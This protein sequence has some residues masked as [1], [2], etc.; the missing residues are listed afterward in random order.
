MAIYENAS[1]ATLIEVKDV[2]H[3]TIAGTDGRQM[4]ALATWARSRYGLNFSH[5]KRS[6]ER[7]PTLGYAVG[8]LQDHLHEG[9]STAANLLSEARKDGRITKV[10]SK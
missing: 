3:F 8:F 2:S 9:S 5:P 4:D 1:K 7:I 10:L 6:Y